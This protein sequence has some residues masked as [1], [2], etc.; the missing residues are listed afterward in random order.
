MNHNNTEGKVDLEAPLADY[1]TSIGIPYVM[2]ETNSLSVSTLSL[3]F[4]KLW[5]VVLIHRLGTRQGRGI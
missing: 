5:A 1:T 3:Q 4:H 2:G